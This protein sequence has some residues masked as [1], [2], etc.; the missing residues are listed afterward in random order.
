MDMERARFQALS[1]LTGTGFTT[2]E[3]EC[4]AQ[5]PLR[6]KIIMSLMVLGHIGLTAIV[7]S[8]VSMPFSFN[9]W[10]AV[11]VLVVVLV[12]FRVATNKLLL[13]YLD[14]KIEDRLIRFNLGSKSL[15][16]VLAVDDR[17]G[18]A[19]VEIPEG[20]PLVGRNLAQADL[21]SQDIL[22]L[23]IR[24]D[25]RVISAPGAGDKIYGNDVLVVYGDMEKIKGMLY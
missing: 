16:E 10:Q 24:G 5:K 6:R 15:A 12:T 22:V 19:E 11:V 21:R 20:H 2:K 7:I 9:W 17:F 1:S 14:S 18:V 3:S 8:A 13:T 4:I 25:D 23:A